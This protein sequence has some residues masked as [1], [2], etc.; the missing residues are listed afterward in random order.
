MLDMHQGLESPIH[1]WFCLLLL[2]YLLLTSLPL[3]DQFSHLLLPLVCDHCPSLAGQPVAW[4]GGGL[5]SVQPSRPIKE[6]GVGEVGIRAKGWLPLSVFV[7]VMVH[8]VGDS[9]GASHLP[10]IQVQNVS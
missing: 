2:F 9:A 6:A 5:C 10:L 7:S 3:W 8:S 4:A 1:V